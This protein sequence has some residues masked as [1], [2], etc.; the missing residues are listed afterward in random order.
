MVVPTDKTRS[1]M[2]IL[3]VKYTKWVNKYICRNAM[4]ITNEELGVVSDSL[5]Q[6]IVENI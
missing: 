4:E 1:Y 5:H 3:T 6:E 2:I